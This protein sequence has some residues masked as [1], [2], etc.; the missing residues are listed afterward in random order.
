MNAKYLFWMI[1]AFL[2]AMTYAQNPESHCGTP[3]KL[4]RFGL[5]FSNSRPT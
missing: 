3:E 4:C 2:S 5:F 1:G